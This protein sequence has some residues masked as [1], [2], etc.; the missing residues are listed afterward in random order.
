M[1]TRVILLVI[2]LAA[3]LWAFRRWRQAVQLALVVLVLE[4]A[5]RKWLLP[6][7]QDLIY[8]AKDA[9]LLAAYAGFWAERGRR[10]RAWKPREPFL[11]GVLT[12]AMLFGLLQVFN[13]ELPN[14][15]VGLL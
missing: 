12:L 14:L 9:L 8:F 2:G 5:I 6:G 7:A 15:L 11:F 4:G 1:N 3:A 13:P 10:G